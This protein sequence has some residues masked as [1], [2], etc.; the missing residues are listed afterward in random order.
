MFFVR[1]RQV[2]DSGCE[3]IES[4]AELREGG[5]R[6]RRIARRQGETASCR[7]RG[8]REGPLTSSL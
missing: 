1:P 6:E 4:V 8:A 7:V 2:R 3:K 5:V